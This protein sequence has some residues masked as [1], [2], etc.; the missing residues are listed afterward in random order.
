MLYL[1][2][3]AIAQETPAGYDPF[4]SSNLDG[5]T[6]APV[7]G[8]SYHRYWVTGDAKYTDASTFVW[9]VENGVFGTYDATNSSWTAMTM[10]S[11]GNGYYV[12]L[13]GVELDGN[14]N[15]S[16]I[17]VRWDDGTTG[18]TG[19]VAVYE[20]SS[21]N[22]IVADQITGYKHAIVA[23]PEVWFIAGNVEQCSDQIY[24]VTIK[25]NNV[26]D[27]SYPYTIGFS[28]PIWDGSSSEDK[29]QIKNGDLDVRLEYTFDLE[30][31][32]N[33]DVT[34]DKQYEVTLLSLRDSFGSTG[35]IAPL[36][37]A[38]G[39]YEK[40]TLTVYHLPQTG[41]MSMD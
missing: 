8:T 26:N 34:S 28:Y 41:G 16:E 14:N 3:S 32:H 20:R 30:A 35:K 23:Q 15:S 1:A 36:G 37:E 29:I 38:Q 2:I 31:V 12:E 11:I 18:S 9:Y 5:L 27:N 25:M 13:T 19:Y 6:E 39:Q 7:V 21:D 33:L 40:M 17:W 22:C 4:V 10:T 24:S